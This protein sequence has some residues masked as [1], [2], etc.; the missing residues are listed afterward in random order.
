MG[1]INVDVLL[2]VEDLVDIDGEVDDVDVVR[3]DPVTVDVALWRD[4]DVDPVVEA[5]VR[6]DDEMLVFVRESVDVGFVVVPVAAAV[7]VVVR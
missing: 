2:L 7:V 1:A 3:V 4:G 6:E 5:D